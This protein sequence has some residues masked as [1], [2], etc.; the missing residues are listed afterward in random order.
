MWYI[1]LG[2][3]SIIMRKVLKGI[4]KEWKLFY[5]IILI[6]FG[7]VILLSV[8]KD[9]IPFGDFLLSFSLLSWYVAIIVSAI[10]ITIKRFLNWEKGVFTYCGQNEE[11]IELEKEIV[12]LR[13]NISEEKNTYSRVNNLYGDLSASL[14]EMLERRNYIRNRLRYTD[15]II[16]MILNIG[17]ALIFALLPEMNK[18]FAGNSFVFHIIVSIFVVIMCIITFPTSIVDP[19]YSKVQAVYEYEEKRLEEVLYRR[20]SEL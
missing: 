11:F 2:G 15:E 10:Y 14:L 4:S 17:I 8:I 9:K 7:L 16:Q 5:I 20:Q 19:E 1:S 18:L 13:N 6:G 12:C 3:S